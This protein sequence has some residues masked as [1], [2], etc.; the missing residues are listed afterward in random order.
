M[1][2][3][4][5]SIPPQAAPQIAITSPLPGATLQGQVTINGTIDVSNFTS[6]ELAFAYASDSTGTWFLLQT[7]SQP[8]VDSTLTVWDTTSLTDG[9][10]SL[11]LRVYLQDGTLQDVTVTDLHLRN[12]A[13]QA[14]PTPTLTL[15]ATSTPVSELPTLESTMP[16]EPTLPAPTALPAVVSSS[17][18][19]PTPLPANPAALTSALIFSNFGRGVLLVLILF[20]VFGMFFRLRKT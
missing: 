12:T 10:Y 20:A 2:V 6:A 9:D 11:R 1:I 18:P 19:T 8:V 5:V 13:T 14:P 16:P 7:F 4:W 17:N 3:F 15:T